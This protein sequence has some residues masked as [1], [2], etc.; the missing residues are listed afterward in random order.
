MKPWSCASMAGEPPAATALF[1]MSSTSAREPHDKAN[2]PS[3][4]RVVSH[5]KKSIDFFKSATG[6]LTKIFR[7]DTPSAR[8]ELPHRPHFDAAL[9]RRRYLGRHLDRLVQISRFDQVKAA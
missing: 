6:R 4:C 3:L 9:A 5:T 7:I 1:T 2:S 8:I